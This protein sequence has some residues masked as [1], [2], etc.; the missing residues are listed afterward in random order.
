MDLIKTRIQ[1]M[2]ITNGVP[3]HKGVVDVATKIVK[4]EGVAGL[5]R[6]GF[7]PFWMKLAPHT[8]LSFVILEECR[9]FYTAWAKRRA[10]AG[11]REHTR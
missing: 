6:R 10:P 8:T 2:T 3:E 5:W 1:N 4:A 7:I 11:S 9:T